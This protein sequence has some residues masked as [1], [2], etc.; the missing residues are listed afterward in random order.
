M[1]G[2]SLSF[3]VV[4]D[5][6]FQRNMLVKMLK[7]MGA[8]M[9]HTASDGREALEHLHKLD[10]P[11]DVIISDLDMPGM[12]GMEFIRH[13]GE[14][15]LGTSLIVASGVERGVLT[16]VETMAAAY[17][18]NFLGTIE[19][20]VTPRKIEELLQINKP[21]LSGGAQARSATPTLPLAEIV[22]GLRAGEFEPFFQPKVCIA[23]GEVVGAEA[24]ARWRHPRQ[25]VISP[26][27]FIKPLEDS[28]NIDMLMR[29]MLAKAATFC[30]EACHANPRFCVAVNLSIKSLSDVKIADDITEIV[31][32]QH[33]DPR[34][35]VLEITE[36][37]ATT[38]IG[39]VLENLA[40]LRIK[41]FELSIDDYGTGYSSLEQLTRI[42][43]TELKID[44][45]FVTHAG[46]H[47]SARVILGSSLE[48][49]RK[50]KLR[51]VAE[52]VETSANWNLLV[53]LGCDIAQGYYISRPMS[54]E[55]FMDWLGAWPKMQ[56]G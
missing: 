38:D 27:L 26:Y 24:L 30:R 3:L 42:P 46:R 21:V 40:R 29:A 4:E 39:R 44:Q 15:G 28:G 25:G 45:S 34:H 41:G 47:E 52:G 54:K 7:H 12:D 31:R 8:Q 32:R 37:T 35:I 16:S 53:D 33:L 11:V 17:G 10:A 50:L 2:K 20:P 23:T 13:I 18:I 14:D 56:N 9:I 55:L 43:F 48:M 51:A 1:H 36:S 5:Q 6:E 22:D 49:A 19:K